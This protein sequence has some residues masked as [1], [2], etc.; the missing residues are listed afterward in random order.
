MRHICPKG[1]ILASDRVAQCSD[2]GRFVADVRAKIGSMGGDEHLELVTGE[3]K[4]HG[5]VEATIEGGWWWEDFFGWGDD[6]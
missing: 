2:C 1:K 3:C 4:R 6:A 5:R